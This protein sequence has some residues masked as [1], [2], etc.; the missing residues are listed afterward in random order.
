MAHDFRQYRQRAFV[1]AS[2][3]ADST[4]PAAKQKFADLAIVWMMLAAQ[5]EEPDCR[6]PRWSEREKEPDA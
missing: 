4:T 3:A 2:R 6:I 1:C 5:F